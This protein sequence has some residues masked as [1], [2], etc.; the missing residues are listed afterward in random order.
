MWWCD[1]MSYH[2][3]HAR[4]QVRQVLRR[5]LALAGYRSGDLPSE[6]GDVPRASSSLLQR[7]VC[8]DGGDCLSGTALAQGRRIEAASRLQ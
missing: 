5:V 7:E 1:V 4:R 6:Q 8:G 3:R 2:S